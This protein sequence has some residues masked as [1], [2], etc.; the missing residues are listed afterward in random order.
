VFFAPL[1]SI[2]TITT[3]TIISDSRLRE[4][5]SA[6]ISELDIKT[7]TD[8]ALSMTLWERTMVVDKSRTM[9]RQLKYLGFWKGE[10][11]EFAVVFSLR[12][13]GLSPA[14]PITG[15]DNIWERM[16]ILLTVPTL[17]LVLLQ[18]GLEVIF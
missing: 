12:N 4:E 13:K 11:Y 5:L 18:K 7:L 9:L 6:T 1:Q 2:D 17:N 10:V 3:A 14:F 15:L 8:A 16:F